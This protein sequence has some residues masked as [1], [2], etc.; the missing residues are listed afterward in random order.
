MLYL[1]RDEIDRWLKE[2]VPYIDLTSWTLGIREQQGSIAYF[3][4]EEAVVCGTEEVRQIFDHLHI[5]TDRFIPSGQQVKQ[6]EVLISGK[7]RAEDLNMAWKVGQNILDHCSGIA[8]KT[9]R[10]VDDAKSINPKVAVLTTRKGFPGTKALTTK[11]I[12]VGG[13]LPHRLGIS[14]T[15]LIFKQHMNMI[16]GFEALLKKLPGIKG[17]CCEKK[18]I[19]ETGSLEQAVSLCQ[20]GAD[21]IQFEKMKS[22]ELKNAVKHLRAEFPHVVALAAGGINESNVKDYAETGVDGIVTTSL[23]SAKPLDIGVKIEPIQIH[24]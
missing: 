2:D 11:S 20:A 4:R 23:F 16:G 18:I 6:G 24:L 15:I 5:E 3:T 13:A 12:M 21:G 14:E 22:A 1:T 9:R 17:E 10:M 19:V 8:T 7:G